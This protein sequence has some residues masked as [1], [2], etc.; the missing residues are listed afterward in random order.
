MACAV[1]ARRVRAR[2]GVASGRAPLR[3][4]DPVQRWL[5]PAEPPSDPLVLVGGW[6][7]VSVVSV[8]AAVVAGGVAALLVAVSA[9]GSGPA[10]VLIRRRGA[11]DRMVAQLPHALD[12]VARG[13]RS[14]LSPAQAMDEVE[15]NLHGRLAADWS[16]VRR[17]REAGGLLADALEGWTEARPLAEVRLAATVLALAVSAGGSRARAV[18][19]VVS[20]LLDEAAAREEIGAQATQAVLSAVTLGVLPV[21]FL[22]VSSSLDPGVGAFLLGSP[23]GVA[24]LVTG[25]ALDA[26]GGVWM[27]HLV[28]RIR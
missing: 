23:L 20:T 12:G 4:P 9:C 14:G 21:A 13:L 25:L 28:G 18:D 16:S 26:A 2:L 1:S 24:C 3:L 6:S 17:H 8:A 19:G 10:W 7:V 27:L 22:A 11:D 15:A 5:E